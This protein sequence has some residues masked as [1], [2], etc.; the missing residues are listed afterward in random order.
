MIVFIDDDR[1]HIASLLVDFVA[2]SVQLINRMAASRMYDNVI[3][4]DILDAVFDGALPFLSG[5]DVEALPPHVTYR[6]RPSAVSFNRPSA[7]GIN[8]IEQSARL[9]NLNSYAPS[10]LVDKQ[11][12]VIDETTN[13]RCGVF[14]KAPV[15][16][17]VEARTRWSLEVFNSKT[18]SEHERVAELSDLAFPNVQVTFVIPFP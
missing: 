4:L 8:R 16:A 7:G 11:R 2:V 18:P 15:S 10:F 13:E 1:E 6:L 9:V 3:S 17:M 5:C 14:S 12:T